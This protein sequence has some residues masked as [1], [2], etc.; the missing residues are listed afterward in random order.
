MDYR[1]ELRDIPE[2]IKA[3]PVDRGYPVPW[4]VK[5][6]D[7][8]PEFRIMDGE[9]YTSAVL[10]KRCWVCGEKLGT[11]LSFVI[12]PMCAI[13]RTSAEPPCH[14]ECAEWSARYCPFLSRPHMVRR[15]DEF[16]HTGLMGEA[17]I[18][19]NPGV[20]GVW[21]TKSYKTFQAKGAAA[22]GVLI[23]MGLPIEVLW[24]AE[25][26]PATRQEVVGSIDG[27]MPLLKEQCMKEETAL[28]RWDAV[29]ELAKARLQVEQWLPA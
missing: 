24:F 9:K 11:Y 22:H 4:F 28:A 25:G 20:A 26:R 8:K 2:R 23:E 15:E 12:G 14:R 6:I 1:P 29:R 19:R 3:L 5:W 7:G 27:G 13:N 17:S 18:T 10:H 21:V 16:V